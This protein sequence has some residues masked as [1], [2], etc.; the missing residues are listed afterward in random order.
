M[1]KN[2]KT[3]NSGLE[4]LRIVSMVMIVALHYFSW[5][6][7]RQAENV[8]T[9]N[10][11]IANV[12]SVFFR[13]AVN[14]FYLISGYFL[15]TTRNITFTKIWHKVKGIWGRAFLCSTLLY[16]IVIFLRIAEFDIKVFIKSFFPIL[17]N[18]YWFI[19]IFILLTI[20]R[21][22]WGRVL[23]ELQ[24]GEL[25]IL[26]LTL[27]TF[28]SIQTTIGI[29][30]FSE[31]GYGF[32]HALTM[33]TLGYSISKFKA[34]QWGKIRSLIIYI[35]VSGLAGII[36]ILQNR[37]IASQTESTIVLYNSPL[38]IISAIALFNFFLHINLS[39]Q[40]I[41]KTSPHVLT[42]YLINDHPIMRQYFW[43][44]V[45]HC[46]IV[47]GSNLMII[48]FVITVLGYMVIGILVDYSGCQIA[49]IIRN[50]IL[51]IMRNITKKGDV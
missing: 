1:K 48:H 12:G 44:R 36:A 50:Y 17:F 38:V 49:L 32:L 15:V 45:L 47:C 46:D 37:I 27:V 10:Y 2:S 23:C 19:T 43:N 8:T 40:W 33:L 42:V 29:N 3:R 51:K 25:V 6:G 39:S 41:L 7:V 21:P 35:G 34:L 28:D 26:V 9:L 31:R 13:P 5:G 22:F 16:L 11:F 20:I 24:N 30:A 4:L 14:C 18:Q